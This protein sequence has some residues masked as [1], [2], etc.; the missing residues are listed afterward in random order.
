VKTV[1]GPSRSRVVRW[2]ARARFRL[3]N[4]AVYA[5]RIHRCGWKSG[6]EILEQPV[7]KPS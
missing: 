4:A 7:R 6:F 2:I 3:G 5:D 1:T